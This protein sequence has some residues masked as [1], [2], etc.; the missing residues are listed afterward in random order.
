VKDYVRLARTRSREVFVD[1]GLVDHRPQRFGRLHLRGVGGLEDEANAVRHGEAGLAMPTGVVERQDDAPLTPGPAS[2][3]NNRS[4]ASK[5]GL[6][7]P[8][9]TYQ[10]LSPVAGETNA[11]T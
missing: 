2:W 10:K 9:E 7:T 8:F 4:G 6:D 3:A 5:N 11:V 1:D